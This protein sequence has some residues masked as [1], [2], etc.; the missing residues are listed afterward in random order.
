MVDDGRERIEKR[1]KERPGE[2]GEMR[3]RSV[4]KRGRPQRERR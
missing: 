2:R 3:E 1:L 4:G